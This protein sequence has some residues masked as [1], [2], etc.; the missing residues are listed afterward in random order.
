MLNDEMVVELSEKTVRRVCDGILTPEGKLN[1]LFEAVFHCLPSESEKRFF[2][3]F[4]E[5]AERSLK[6]DGDPDPN[7]RAFSLVCQTMFSMSR[8]QFIE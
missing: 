1:A 5:T 7:H 8:F 3:R 6:A 2:L 4:V